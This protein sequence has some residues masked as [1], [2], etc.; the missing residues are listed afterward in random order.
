MAYET[1]A[2]TA[3]NRSLRPF[4]K[5]TEG[6][7]V[8]GYFA[9]FTPNKI[10]PDRLDLNFVTK[11]GMSVKVPRAGKLNYLEQDLES[12]G[13]KLV[14]GAMTKLTCTGFYQPKGRNI[15]SPRYTIAQD[16]QD[17]KEGV[18]ISSTEQGTPTTSED[19][20]KRI[21]ELKAGAK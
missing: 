16:L 12:S 11:E 17:V 4:A 1:V 9:G 5:F 13:K 19:V 21:E 18:E 20:K 3:G 2:G 10:N 8:E 15:D 7:S 14:T 6:E